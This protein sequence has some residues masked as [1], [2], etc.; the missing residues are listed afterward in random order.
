MYSKYRDVT[1][2]VSDDH[3]TL[4]LCMHCRAISSRLNVN[5]IE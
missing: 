4:E 1:T 2:M 5:L 3:D